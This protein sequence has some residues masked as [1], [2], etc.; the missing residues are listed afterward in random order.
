M[1]KWIVTGL[2]TGYLPV[3][4]GTWGSAAVAVLFVAAALVCRR[5]TV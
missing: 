3:A 5:S 4:P 1:R 2:G